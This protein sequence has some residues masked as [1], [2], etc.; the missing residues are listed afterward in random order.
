MMIRWTGLAPWEFE[1]PFPGSLTSTFLIRDMGCSVVEIPDLLADAGWAEAM[2]GC[3]GFAHVPPHPTPN[4]CVHEP[5]NE[6]TGSV[7]SAKYRRAIISFKATRQCESSVYL[8]SNVEWRCPTCWR[9][10]AGPRPW[11]AAPDSLTY[12]YTLHP[13]CRPTRRAKST[14]LYL[15]LSLGH[16]GLRRI[17][18]CTPKPYT[19][20]P[21]PHTLHPT[22]Y[23]LHPI[24]Y[25]LHP[26]PYSL[27]LTHTGVI[28]LGSN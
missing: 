12:P 16:G 19:P 20:H 7:P 4:P 25:T 13:T 6:S 23:T 22:P 14:S 24:S 1:S 11:L 27:A 2:A 9:M 18:P 3:S 17:R 5:S 28:Y 10:R 21:T 26:T 8:R 15:S